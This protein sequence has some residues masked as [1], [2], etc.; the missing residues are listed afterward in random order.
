MPTQK[1]SSKMM[2]AKAAGN[3]K[4]AKVKLPAPSAPKGRFK[5]RFADS[6]DSDSDARPQR[7]QS[8]FVDSDDSDEDFEL[9]P[10]LAP[11]RGIPRKAGEE[12]GDSTDLE[13]EDSEAERTAAK[14]SKDIEKGDAPVKNGTANGQ[15]ALL[16]AGSLRNSK[17][18][19]A[20]ELPTF[21]VE[22]KTK[23]K[24]GF[25]GLGK[26]KSPSITEADGVQPIGASDIPMPPAHRQRGVRPLTPIGE[27]KPINGIEAAEP[28]A[29]RSPKLQ[30]R[31][32]PQ[33][34]RS[35]S[36]SWPLPLPPQISEEQRP[37]SSDGVVPLRTSM[38]PIMNKRHS[39]QISTSARSIIDPKSG[40]EVTIGRTGKKKKFQGLRRVFG[41]ND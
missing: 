41:L 13:D 30:R 6:D 11:V 21:D 33:F 1:T 24:R 35:T 39:S 12:D 37:Q 9:P 27:D 18:A 14:A 8:R 16:A 36:D 20:Q 25:F 34:G 38:R 2:P 19:P 32:T 15:G 29:S 4:P 5:S 31:N 22:K 17:Y 26:K 40:K 7:F 10:G 3:A 23:A 28:P